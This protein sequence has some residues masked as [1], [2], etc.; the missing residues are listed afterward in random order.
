[1][2]FDANQ[3]TIFGYDAGAMMSGRQA[4]ARRVGFPASGNNGTG[5]TTQALDLF[6]AA[7]GWAVQ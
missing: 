7:V 5:P 6:E 4:P 2:P 3:A 1:M